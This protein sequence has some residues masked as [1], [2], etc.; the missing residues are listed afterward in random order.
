MT[1]PGL[2]QHE[3]PLSM[4]AMY[5]L[6]CAIL[7][8]TLLPLAGVL[9]AQVNAVSVFVLPLLGISIALKCARSARKAI[10]QSNGVLRGEGLAKAA[11]RLSYAQFVL[12]ALMLLFSPLITQ[13]VLVH[14][15]SILVP[16]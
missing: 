12:F 2:V 6:I 13:S 14:H 5:S 7:A 10:H 4:L 3:Q 8:W 16:Q 11:E 15:V 9:L 1:T